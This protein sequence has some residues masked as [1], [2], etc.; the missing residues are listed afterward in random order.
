M[1]RSEPRSMSRL[2]RLMIML[3]PHLCGNFLLHGQLN[4]LYINEAMASNTSGL[5][6]ATGAIEDWVEIYNSSGIVCVHI[7]W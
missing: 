4:D 7:T 3:L 6:D 1:E 5:S 2:L